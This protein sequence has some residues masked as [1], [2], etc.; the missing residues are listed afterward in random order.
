MNRPIGLGTRLLIAQFI[1]ILVA[2]ATLAGTVAMVAPILFLEH[3][4]MTGEDSPVVQQHAMAAFES[5]V[6]VAFLAAA[7]AAVGTAVLLSWLLARRV[8]KPV[9]DLAAAAAAVATGTY[10][11][12]VPATG[13]GPELAALATAFQKMADDLAA[14]DAARSRLLAD[15]AHEL[16]TPLATLEVHIDGME[17]GIVPTGSETYDVMRAQVGRLRRLATDIRLTAAAQEHALDL[18]PRPVGVTDLIQKACE[19][20]APRFAAHHV[21][22]RCES[23]S[24]AATVAVDPD[25]IQQ[26]LG[27][28][29]DNALRHTPA[30]GV[31]TVTAT[32]AEAGATITIADTGDGVPADQLEVM[33][34]RFHRIDPARSNLGE[35]GSGL[36]LTIARAI[37]EDHH[38]TLTAASPGP[39]CGTTL[40]M[41]LPIAADRPDRTDRH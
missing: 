41:T 25:R 21:G 32:V 27:N 22:L 23:T 6:G 35:P 40:S 4:D 38:G 14:T 39:G 11:I 20:A 29:L 15:L 26:V 16:R 18:H 17:D 3:L 8:S 28:L 7:A 31:V 10:D 2:G 24:L 34:E 30:G 9:E 36:G 13:F 37:V 12:R 19:A 1:V 33:F 5:A